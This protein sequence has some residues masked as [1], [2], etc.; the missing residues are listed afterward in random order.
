MILRR[1]T[2]TSTQYL[3]RTYG[4]ACSPRFVWT[5]DRDAALPLTDADAQQF[6]RLCAVRSVTLAKGGANHQEKAGTYEVCQ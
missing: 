5:C 3:S 4:P 1:T 2:T 6:R